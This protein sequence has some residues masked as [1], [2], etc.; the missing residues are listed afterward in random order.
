V[1]ISFDRLDPRILPD[2]GVK[3]A[4]L[5]EDPARKR[6][7]NQEQIPAAKALIPKSAVHGEGS[8]SYVFA[9][10]DGKL[11]RRAVSL[12]RGMAGDVEVMAGVNTGDAIVVSGPENLRDGEKVEIR[13]QE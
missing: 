1:R 4:F 8:A 7:R 6:A 13:N 10:H 3:V 2:M 12:G 9:V 11:E 5:S